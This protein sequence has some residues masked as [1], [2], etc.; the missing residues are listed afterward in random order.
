[1]QNRVLDA[2]LFLG[3][4]ND[5]SA[6][7]SSLIRQNMLLN[8]LG[9]LAAHEKPELQNAYGLAAAEQHNRTSFRLAG[10]LAGNMLPKL[11]AIIEGIVYAIFPLIF[12]AL[13][14]PQGGKFLGLYLR[15]LVWLQLWPILYSVMTMANAS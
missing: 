4:Y 14:L 11:R 1:M 6:T 7:G 12:L 15:V 2:Y 13:L 3:D 5:I 8:L 10:G 9:D